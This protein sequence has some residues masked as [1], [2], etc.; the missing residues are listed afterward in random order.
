MLVGTTWQ[1]PQR[2]D[3]Q[4]TQRV[5]RRQRGHAPMTIDLGQRMR[6]PG[7][8][9]P[10]NNDRCLFFWRGALVLAG[11]TQPTEKI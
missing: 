3:S 9:H 11:K 10:A 7:E 1:C 2:G 8:V 6:C 5:A 4:G